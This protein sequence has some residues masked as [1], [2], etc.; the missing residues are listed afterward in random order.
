MTLLRAITADIGD[1]SPDQRV[2]PV[3]RRDAAS[4]QRLPD[5]LWLGWTRPTVRIEWEW[6]SVVVA[7]LHQVQECIRLLAWLPAWTGRSTGCSSRCRD[8]ET[9]PVH[10]MVHILRFILPDEEVALLHPVQAQAEAEPVEL[11]HR[12]PWA[13]IKHSLD[14]DMRRLQS[15]RLWI[16]RRLPRAR[17]RLAVGRRIVSTL[18]LRWRLELQ[19]FVYVVSVLLRAYPPANVPELERVPFEEDPRLHG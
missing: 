15:I 12:R 9:L 3:S 17:H 19:P 16:D 7:S 5:L 11:E 10:V 6:L 18:C 1:L 2:F 4:C 13:E 8:V 14:A